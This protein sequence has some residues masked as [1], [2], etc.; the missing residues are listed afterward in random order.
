MTHSQGLV[1]DQQAF[2]LRRTEFHGTVASPR[3]TLKWY[4]MSATP[5]PVP[6][7]V[8]ASAQ[9]ASVGMVDPGG[10]EPATG[11][12]ILHLG[13]EADWLQ[14]CWWRAD[15]LHARLFQ[16]PPGSGDPFGEPSDDSVRA[17]V[18]ELEVID[19]ERRAWAT[20]VLA[21][22]DRAGT[23]RAGTGVATYLQRGLVIPHGARL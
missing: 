2:E 6:T 21:G 23:D 18:W 15:I 22:T 20:H 5:D 4:T 3:I 10:N 19:F 11:F 1:P 12:A 14:I 8:L 17:C 7:D 16:R 13:E 9:E